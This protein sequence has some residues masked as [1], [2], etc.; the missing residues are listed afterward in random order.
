M[1]TSPSQATETVSYQCRLLR[2][3]WEVYKPSGDPRFGVWRNALH[4]RCLRCGMTRHDAFDVLGGLSTRRYMPPE[5]YYLSK[6]EE[7]PT[8]E[9][10]R[11][12]MLKHQ[13]RLG[14]P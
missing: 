11:L 1:T 4:L 9:Q 3:A 13:R 7:K 2:H 8:T 5:N 14:K 6:D 12:W 10:L